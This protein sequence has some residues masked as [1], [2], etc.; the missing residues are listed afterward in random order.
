MR[1]LL[2][3]G[4]RHADVET[5]GE[6]GL[7]LQ[8]RHDG[9]KIGITAALAEPV[10]GA[11]DLTCA[12]AHGGKRIG[13]RLLGIVVGMNADVIT[14]DHLDHLADDLFHLVRQRAA[15]GVAQHHPARALVIGGLGAG[16]RELRIS[17]VA[18]EE[19]LAVEQD[20]APLGSGR[21][22]A[23]ANRGQVFLQAGLERDAHV[24]VPRLRHEADGVRL[25]REQRREP[26]I[27]RGRAA[28]P[29]RHTERGE[30]GVELAVL[31]EQLGVGHVRAG[32]AALDIIDAELG[33]HVR[34]RELV[35][36]G[37]VDAVGLRA[38][39]Q[40]GV[41]QIEAFTG[42]DGTQNNRDTT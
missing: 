11:L 30:G 33:Q 37:E 15:V 16:E 19:M 32:I 40:R 4:V 8:R 34:D 2:E 13:Y 38:V 12:G 6:F 22:H 35:A 14:G 25:G 20:F 3:L 5:V 27:V 17:L 23:V 41:E 36:E 42:H 9:D 10:E 21:A 18:V 24:V 29:A 31:G 1:E 39:A 26:G 28:G 7:E